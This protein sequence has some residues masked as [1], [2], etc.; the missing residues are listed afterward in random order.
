MKPTSLDTKYM[1]LA[2]ALAKKGAGKV[3]P[4][5][6]VGC[7]IVK[8]GKIIGKGRHEY[9]GGPHA[10]I[11]ALKSA[12]NRAN[13]ADMYVTLEPCSH[14]GKTPPC[15]DAIIKA[16]INKVYVAMKDPNPRVSGAGI[17]KLTENSIKTHT[18]ILQNS[19]KSM[20][21]AY[22]GHIRPRKSR[23]TV[24]AAMTLDGKIA[25][26]TG[27]SRWITSPKSRNLVHKLRS[28]VDGILV[29]INT[30][31]KDNPALT[32][33]GSGRNPVRVVIDPSL[34]IPISNRILDG[35][36]P[37]IIIHSSKTLKAKLEVLKKRKVLAVYMKKNGK[38]IDFKQIIKKLNNMSIFSILIEG[39]GETI[40]SA[41]NAS[42]VNDV[43]FFI[44]PKLIGGRDARSPVEGAGIAKMAKAIPVKNW[45]ITHFGPDI[46]I[47]GRIL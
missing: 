42:V 33:H 47:K 18:G 35:S 29:G 22:L 41:L 25:S 5:P 28:S 30:V 46:M 1:K 12:G 3:F 32:S 14:H 45:K 4:N 43:V 34:K 7:V 39:G 17:R 9:F 15:T 19:S 40:A 27:N 21:K 11:N 38:Q 31:L 13:G 6:M 8:N 44:A 20:N 23:V 36:A 26:F 37:T 2:L 24:K 16:G 10:E